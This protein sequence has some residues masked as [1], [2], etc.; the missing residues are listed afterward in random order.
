LIGCLLLY[1]I[2]LNFHSLHHFH[3]WHFFAR[4]SEKKLHAR[5]LNFQHNID[6]IRCN[7]ERIVFKV[8]AAILRRLCYFVAAAL[9]W[10]LFFFWLERW[11]RNCNDLTKKK[12]KCRPLKQGLH[13]CLL[14]FGINKIG[15][16]VKRSLFSFILR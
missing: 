11:S 16:I 4:I 12:H 1:C 10:I 8:T 15:I 9:K 2:P 7:M 6:I 13:N 5:V 14:L 3:S